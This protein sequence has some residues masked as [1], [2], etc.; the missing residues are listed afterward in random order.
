MAGERNRSVQMG[1]EVAHHEFFCLAYVAVRIV[2]V[3]AENP[4]SAASVL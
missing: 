4:C 2:V 1:R 3:I